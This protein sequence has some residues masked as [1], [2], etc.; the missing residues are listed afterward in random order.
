MLSCR[1]GG[2]LPGDRGGS[3]VVLRAVVRSHGWQCRGVIYPLSQQHVDGQPGLARLQDIR[4]I[5]ED[6]PD[7][8]GQRDGVD[9]H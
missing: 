6:L 1:G 2:L 8:L 9:R 4:H 3:G 5:L 7:A